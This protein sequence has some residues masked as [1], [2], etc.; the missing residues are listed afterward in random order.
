M[1][2]YYR[3][4]IWLLLRDKAK[5]YHVKG[6]PGAGEAEDIRKQLEELD[7]QDEEERN[8]MLANAVV[9]S[10]VQ[11]VSKPASARAKNT[12]RKLQEVARIKSCR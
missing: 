12:A 7:R 1:S 9:E 8:A 3:H 11:A 6:I 4:L 2:D 10:E 5:Q